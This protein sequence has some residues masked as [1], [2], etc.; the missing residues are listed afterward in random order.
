MFPIRDD[1]R[2]R[3][4]PFVTW[5][6][7]ALNGWVFLEELRQGPLLQF[8]VLRHALVPA[9][10]SPEDLVT[11]MFLHGGWMHV[12]SNLWMLAIFGDNVE[13][14]LGHLRF[15]GFY[16]AGGLASGLLHLAT[17][18]GSMVPTIGA[19]GAIAAVMG[20][21]LRLFPRAR[22]KALVP[23]FIFLHVVELPAFLFLGIWF[24]IQLYSGVL[25]L[26][27]AFG[28]IAWWAHIGGFMAGF[29]MSARRR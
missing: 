11:S 6:I 17:H 2:L 7:I 29:A 24:L 25:S 23:V 27:A 4:F 18:W 22:I 21:Y 5:A 15:L 13:D 8:F 28:G 12:L 26:G 9:A 19:S 16:L 14:R 1:V 3:S 10:F 20:G